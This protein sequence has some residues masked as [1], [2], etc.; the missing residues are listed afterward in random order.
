MTSGVKGS[1]ADEARRRWN[2]PVPAPAFARMV[3]YTV[4]AAAKFVTENASSTLKLSSGEK[5]GRSRMFRRAD[6][7]AQFDVL[8]ESGQRP[9]RHR[10]TLGGASGSGCEDQYQGT[11]TAHGFG[12]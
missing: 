4:G 6:G 3:R 5:P 2:G 12:R 8:A 11:V 10:H 1:P 9:E 7:Q